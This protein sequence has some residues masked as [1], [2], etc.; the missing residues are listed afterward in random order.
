VT[1]VLTEA[2]VA[3]YRDNGYYFPIEALSAGEVAGF[4]K[5]LED[6]EA[7]SG[8]PIKGEMRHRS[9]VLFAWIDEMIRHPKILDA[10]EDVLGPDILCWNTSFFIKEARDPGFVSWH[11][12]ATYWGLSSSDVMTAWIA[13]SP[14]NKVSGCMKFVAGT[15][16]QQVAH[17]DTFNKDNLLTRGQEIAVEVN[18]AD[19]VHVELKPGQASLHHVLLFHGSEPNQSDQ[20]RIGLAVRYI[21]TRLKQAVGSRDWATLVRGKDSY[22]HFEPAH[23]PRRD[24]EPEALAFHRMVSEEQ[25]KVLYRGTGKTAYRA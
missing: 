9:H 14:A 1:K 20:R 11:Q 18:E 17:A 13:M 16:R 2:E 6:Y 23:V 3:S 10:V 4:R 22:H 15:H 24:L 7:E 8:S 21:P 25:V 12:D 19:A 5:K